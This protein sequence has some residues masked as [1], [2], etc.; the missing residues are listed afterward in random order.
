MASCRMPEEFFD[1]VA[2][3]LPPD[4]PVGPAGGR[5]PT[6]NHTVMNVLASPGQSVNF[7]NSQGQQTFW[8]PHK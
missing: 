3:H 2:H 1:I 6:T 5:P 8:R 7:P 4:E